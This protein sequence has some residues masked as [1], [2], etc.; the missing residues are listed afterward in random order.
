MRILTFTTKR[1]PSTWNIS[2]SFQLCSASTLL[3]TWHL[4]WY[5]GQLLTQ[6]VV[7]GVE[8]WQ[9]LHHGLLRNEVE[10]LCNFPVLYYWHAPDGVLPLDTVQNHHV[11]A[12]A[13]DPAERVEVQEA[14]H[15]DVLEA[16]SPTAQA[17]GRV[18]VRNHKDVKALCPTCSL[19]L[20]QCLG[21]RVC[22]CVRG[23]QVKD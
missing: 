20:N 15:A 23:R 21:V 12:G 7:I 5:A 18:Q 13:A 8:E 9:L 10:N 2:E 22:V 11:V 17:A 4:C 1:H 19:Q 3:I 16:F 6:N 14:W